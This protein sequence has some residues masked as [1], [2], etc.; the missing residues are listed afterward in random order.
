MESERQTRK[1]R[2]DPFLTSL[3]W[4]V[5]PYDE[6]IQLSELESCAIEEYP[7]DNGPADY[8]LVIDGRLIWNNRSE[9]AYARA[10]KRS[11]SGAALL[12]R[13]LSQP[14]ELWWLS[15]SLSLLNQRRGHLVS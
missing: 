1:R 8:A 3:G 12:A 2:I 13:L 11:Y 9:E 15:S 7:T 14:S 4:R 10:S 5:V 6:S